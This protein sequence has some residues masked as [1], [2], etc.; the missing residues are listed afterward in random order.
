M[1]LVVAIVKPFKLDD[2]KTRRSRVRRPGPDDHRGAGL[3]PP[4]RPHRGL[5]RRGVHDRLRAEGEARD[6]R[7][8]RRRRPVL[9]ER[10]MEA[11]RT[12]KIGDGKVWMVPVEGVAP[13]SDGR[14]RP[15]RAVDGESST[16]VIAASLRDGRAAL[17]ADTALRGAAFGEALAD[18]L[19]AAL[20]SV[21]PTPR[22]GIV[23]WRSWRSGPTSAGSCA[24]AP[25]S[26]CCCCTT[27]RPPARDVVKDLAERC[28]YPL[29]D[30]GF[31]TGHGRRTVKDSIA[32]ADEDLDALTAL[33]DVRH[34]RGRRDAHRRAVA[35]GPPARGAA[36]RRVLHAAGRRRRAPASPARPRRG[37]ARARP[38]GRRRRPARPPVARVGRLGARRG[39]VRRP[40]DARLPDRRPMPR[41]F[42][43]RA[44]LLLDV[45]VALHRVD[46]RPHRP[47]RAAGTRRRRGRCSGSTDADALVRDLSTLG[48]DVAWISQR[49]VVADAR[50]PRAARAAASRT[51][52]GARRGRRVARRPGHRHRRTTGLG[53][54]RARRRPRPPPKP[55]CRSSGPRCSGCARC[56]SRPGTSGSA[57][58][59]CACCA[60]ARCD[61]GVRGARPRRRARS[62]PSRSGSTCGPARN[63]TRTTASPSTGTCSKPS[64]ECAALLDAGETPRR[65]VRRRRRPR[66]PATRAAAARRAAARHRQ[67]HAR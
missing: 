9:A 57:P 50:P 44:R 64:R 1:K 20:P 61:P 53:V 23:A 41:G 66:L 39:R 12:G 38:Q 7:R 3:R 63:A 60:P 33:L 32:L 34:R 13:H 55:S 45:R 8:R 5:P 65:R 58:R 2:V 47:A 54:A 16:G 24:R 37:D 46:E 4:A 18:A 26:T 31:V 42:A 49:R 36:G 17:V 48:R 21:R 6:P 29:W 10:I 52:T 43:T 67:G 59:S 19:D 28:W 22:P 62:A 40:R 27:S 15:R 25:T 56:P 11:A 30:A 51:A 35:Q 14:S